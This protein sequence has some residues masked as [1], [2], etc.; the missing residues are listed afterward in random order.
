MESLTTAFKKTNII[1]GYFLEGVVFIFAAGGRNYYLI[2]L[3]LFSAFVFYLSYRHASGNN[4][5]RDY[6]H[7]GKDSSFFS[8][9]GTLFVT[10]IGT[11]SLLSVV[12]IS[13]V[14]G[15]VGYLYYVSAAFGIFLLAYCFCDS[16]EKGY[17]SLPGELSS[18]YRAPRYFE[19][20]I[21]VL[22]IVVQLIFA[23][24]II[25]G[26][27]QLLSYF[28]TISKPALSLVIFLMF[29]F[30]VLIGGYLAVERADCIRIW[31][32]LVGGCILL[33][34]S[35][36]AV[37]GYSAIKQT[38]I[39]LGRPEH[40]SFLGNKALTPMTFLSFL[41]ASFCL[42]IVLPLYRSS[43]YA[44][45]NKQ[46]ARS[47]VFFTGILV[48]LFSFI[49]TMTGMASS[50]LAESDG[51]VNIIANP[52][53]AFAFIADSVAGPW[54]CFLFILMGISTVISAVD[55]CIMSCADILTNNIIS[56]IRKTHLEPKKYNY[57]SRSS[58]VAMTFLAFSLVYLSQFTNA[59]NH[60][61]SVLIPALAAIVLCGR[62]SRSPKWP[63]AIFS[64][65]C[66][67]S[68]GEYILLTTGFSDGV[69]FF[70][71]GPTVFVF[72]TSLVAYLLSS[73]SVILYK[74]YA[75]SKRKSG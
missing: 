70:M 11:V 41:I 47:A 46:T 75:R 51:A 45:E 62:F 6:F 34:K 29:F 74:N 48:L 32:I 13:F 43:I 36:S 24:G 27:I 60:I 73:R 15:T 55:S 65:V 2:L 17:T 7:G 44:A 21:G 38:F 10:V 49:P 33:Y 31:I 28:T 4:K 20:G 72:L 69:F 22:L 23:S 19:I 35:L 57:L 40:L 12:Q 59:F 53:R 39:E 14:K 30:Y 52:D 37:G 3:L 18:Q 26:G 68:V 1:K 9:V 42:I 71:S 63:C 58:V 54:L 56:V 16:R 67:C 8:T 66:S 61:A 50:V 5:S 64:L 25:T